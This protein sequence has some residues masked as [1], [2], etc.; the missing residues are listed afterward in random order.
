MPTAKPDRVLIAGED[1]ELKLPSPHLSYSQIDLYRKCPK[2]Y[3]AQ[4]ILGQRE[5]PSAAMC[6]GTTMGRTLEQSGKHFCIGGQHFSLEKVQE[7]HAEILPKEMKKAKASKAEVR[8]AGDRGKD[9]LATFWEMDGGSPD[10]HPVLVEE[11][12]GLEVKRTVEF[13]GVPVVVIPDVVEKNAILDFKV[14]G[15]KRFYNPEKSLQLTMYAAVFERPK[16][17][18][19][20]FEKKTGRVEYLYATRDV[21]KSRK[22]VTSVVSEV[23]Y[24]ISMGVFPKCAPEE[25]F[26][27]SE[28]WCGYW[29]S[30]MGK[31]L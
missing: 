21:K 5:P 20:V 9:F 28:K 17:A 15:T 12:P 26:L 2:K 8:E 14:A 30:C 22:W 27:C 29:P 19:Y 4:R 10:F 7:V 6:E 18:Y 31:Y 16:V 11:K 1:Y 23:A 3:F 24:A 13:A 25:N